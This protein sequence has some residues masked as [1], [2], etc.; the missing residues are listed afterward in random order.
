MPR[1]SVSVICVEPWTCRSGP[2]PDQPR[3]AQVLHD[4]RVDPGGGDRARRTATA[5]GSSSEKIS[6]LN[7][8]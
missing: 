6:V 8:T 4:D 3:Q 5:S 1:G 7:V 2:S